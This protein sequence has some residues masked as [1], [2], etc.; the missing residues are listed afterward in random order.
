MASSRSLFASNNSDSDSDNAIEELRRDNNVASQNILAAALDSS[1]S[2]G[3][4]PFS[5]GNK[6]SS[7]QGIL[8][9]QDMSPAEMATFV[10]GPFYRDYADFSGHHVEQLPSSSSAIPTRHTSA[11]PPRVTETRYTI[12]ENMPPP[13]TPGATPSAA[14]DATAVDV[15]VE[16]AAAAPAGP[17]VAPI[18][19]VPAPPAVA[20]DVADRDADFSAPMDAASVIPNHEADF[21]LPAPLGGRLFSSVPSAQLDIG[22]TVV[23]FGFAA[24]GASADTAVGIAAA[25]LVVNKMQDGSCDAV[26]AFV[27]N[28]NMAAIHPKVITFLPNSALET[29]FILS[30]A[31]I[32]TRN[33]PFSIID[34]VKMHGVK[35]VGAPGVSSVA[36]P[37][38]TNVMTLESA[39]SQLKRDAREAKLDAVFVLMRGDKNKVDAFV[40]PQRDLGSET[41]ISAVY[42]VLSVQQTTLPL[43]KPDNLPLFL[44]AQ[45]GSTYL[46]LKGKG[47]NI[48]V[49]HGL[50]APAANVAG[51][52]ENLVQLADTVQ[53][54]FELYGGIYAA[55]GTPIGKVDPLLFHGLPTL[56][57]SQFRD[58]S[59]Q[60]TYLGGIPIDSVVQATNHCFHALGKFFRDRDNALIPLSEFKA[61]AAACLDL[62][63]Q[64]AVMDAFTAGP[65][66]RLFIAPQIFTFDGTAL[67]SRHES[68][69]GPR[70]LAG[71]RGFAQALGSS[72]SPRPP[73]HKQPRVHVG[74]PANFARARIPIASQPLV[75]PVAGAGRQGPP[76]APYICVSDFVFKLDAA[77]FPNGCSTP[78]NCLRRHIPLPPVGQFAAADKTEILQSL[79]KMKGT[80]VPSMVALVQ[81]RV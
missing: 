71:K 40:G 7:S 4:F 11:I 52:F 8:R 23:V 13:H 46:A 9:F 5:I 31:A 59:H 76:I 6:A 38:S 3:R 41:V 21:L 54:I 55:P 12:P 2:S 57:L 37:P 47:I 42:S 15:E 34:A 25:Y 20:V 19:P 73:V 1:I 44:G 74:V 17:A 68:V 27:L 49:Q 29:V 51:R 78:N 22:M 81:A 56:M 53:G 66:A 14:A 80:R 18:P 28:A 30:T 45:F 72:S 65:N 64:A 79:Q 77:R 50:P 48:T 69:V 32:S 26:R 62:K 75:V 10:D 58:T 39:D 70:L 33:Y 16:N 43:A 61:G 67:P 24:P 35:M 36:L 63:P 60:G